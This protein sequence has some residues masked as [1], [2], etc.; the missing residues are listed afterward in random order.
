VL[1]WVEVRA[2][3][4][5]SGAIHAALVPGSTEAG[6]VLG[7]HM[8]GLHTYLAAQHTTV[9]SL[10]M[11]AP[12]RGAQSEVGAFMNGAGQPMQQGSGQSA[13]QQPQP[14]QQ[15]E[16]DPMNAELSFAPQLP[17]TAEAERAQ[18]ARG[19]HFSAVA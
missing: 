14:A 13:Q 8:D 3:S 19:V 11:A 1:G 7:T 2:E 15:T 6:Q 9:E 4:T 10:V 16:L 5:S 12:A 18:G 17:S